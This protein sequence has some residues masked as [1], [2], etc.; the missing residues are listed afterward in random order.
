M[1]FTGSAEIIADITSTGETIKANNLRVLKDGKILKS[2]ACI[3]ISKL[4][5][6]NKLVK[7]IVKLLSK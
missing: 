4:A 5:S 3:M 7:K 2:E 1:P 6:K